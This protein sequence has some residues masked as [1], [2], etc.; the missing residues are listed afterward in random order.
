[1][2]SKSILMVYSRLGVLDLFNGTFLNIGLAAGNIYYFNVLE[3]LFPSYCPQ[4]A[5]AK[6]MSPNACV[7]LLSTSNS[8]QIAIAKLLSP[9]ACLK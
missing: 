2:N 9:N 6:L 4:I 5:I 8:P 1:M 7:K 3:L